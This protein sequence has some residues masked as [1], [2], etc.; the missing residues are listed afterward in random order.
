MV[1]AERVPKREWSRVCSVVTR[2][3][4]A[5]QNA[6]GR[7]G[8]EMFEAIVILASI[9]ILAVEIIEFRDKCEQFSTRMCQR[10]P[11]SLMLDS[12]DARETK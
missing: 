1:G 4:S 9:G 2:R 7:E 12:F 3:G 6:D 11:M 8:T 10:N 5:P